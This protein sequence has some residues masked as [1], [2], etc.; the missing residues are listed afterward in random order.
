M[1]I[2]GIVEMVDEFD[3][4]KRT[5]ID[6][7]NEVI[8]WTPSRE[9]KRRMQPRDPEW[10]DIDTVYSSFGQV[11]DIITPISLLRTIAG[12]SMDGRLYI[13]H[14]LKEVRALGTPNTAEY[15]AAVT[16]QPLDSSRPNPKVVAI[17]EDIDHAVVEGMWRVVNGGGTGARIQMAGFDIAGKTGTAQVVGLGKDTGKN[18]DHSWF[19]SYAPAYKPE[20]AMVALIENSGFG[21]SHAAPAVRG[22]YDVYYRKTRHEEPPGAVAKQIPKNENQPA[23]KSEPA[24]AAQQTAVNNQ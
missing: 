7:P 2:D 8:S 21:G 14:L 24:T 6:L 11:Y 23:K 4:N 3:L 19:V 17:P 9:F 5:G 12:I 13:P 15:K 22:V 20:I 16:F 10:R 1:G 18:K